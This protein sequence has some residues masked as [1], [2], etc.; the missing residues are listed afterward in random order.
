[1]WMWF[2]CV[3]FVFVA[4]CAVCLSLAWLAKRP[5]H[6]ADDG[7]CFG[8]GV[9]VSEAAAREISNAISEKVRLKVNLIATCAWEGS[10]PPEILS[11]LHSD[12]RERKKE[13]A[14]KSGVS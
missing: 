12:A 4:S 11:V 7:L 2:V 9:V 3:S 6:A 5:S 1:M 10:S 8:G 13:V 14:M